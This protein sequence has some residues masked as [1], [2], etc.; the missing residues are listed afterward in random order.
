MRVRMQTLLDALFSPPG[1]S[2]YKAVIQLIGWETFQRLYDLKKPILSALQKYSQTYIFDGCH[3]TKLIKYGNYVDVD[4]VR[5][6]LFF[7][8]FLPVLKRGEEVGMVE[9]HLWILLER[10]EVKSYM[11]RNIADVKAVFAEIKRIVENDDEVKTA[12]LHIE[13][14]MRDLDEELLA[15]AFDNIEHGVSY[16]RGLIADTIA[17]LMYSADKDVLHTFVKRLRGQ[18]EPLLEALNVKDVIAAE[19]KEAVKADGRIAEKL[20]ALKE[21]GISLEE[22]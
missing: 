5:V 11:V 8:T 13:A 4:Q 7:L 2:S 14:R 22:R 1:S 18:W 19:V 10:G 6:D 3:V 12:A 15:I 21:L 16:L 9:P 20:E 17:A